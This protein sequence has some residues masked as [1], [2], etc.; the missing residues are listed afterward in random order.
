MSG[1]VKETDTLERL[2]AS[3]CSLDAC[4]AGECMVQLP[5]MYADLLPATVHEWNL[6]EKTVTLRVGLLKGKFLTDRQLKGARFFPA[7][8]QGQPRPTE[9]Q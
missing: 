9:H 2:P 5:S 8:T 3:A 7:N 4:P 6:I 1:G